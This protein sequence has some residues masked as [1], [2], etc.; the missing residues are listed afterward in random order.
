MNEMIENK[1]PSEVLCEK[2]LQLNYGEL[3][4]HAEISSIIKEEY[5]SMKYNSVIQN[6]KKRLLKNQRAIESIR[7]Q[8]YR[9]VEPDAFVDLSLGHYK[10][11]FKEMQK[12][13]D[14]LR[15]APAKD[16]SIE[17]R[18]TY[19]RVQDR[20]NALQ[21]VLNGACVELKEL[22]TKDG[23]RNHPMAIENIKSN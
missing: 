19:H 23:A 15:F 5:G 12:G 13:S 8:G 4:T 22:R 14:T 2:I 10:K 9:V 20:A 7:G 21:A 1:R 16:M 18:N 11:G 6:T 17:G 3:I